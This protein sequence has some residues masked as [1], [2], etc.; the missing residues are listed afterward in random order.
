MY[1]AAQTCYTCYT[2][3]TSLEDKQFLTKDISLEEGSEVGKIFEMELPKTGTENFR[4]PK[5]KLKPLEE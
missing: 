5:R 2:I 3:N 4:P 1:A